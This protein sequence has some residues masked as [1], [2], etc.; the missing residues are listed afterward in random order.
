M[1]DFLDTARDQLE[2]VRGLTRHVGFKFVE[3]APFPVG[4]GIG[5]AWGKQEYVVLTVAGGGSEHQLSI[6][7][8]VLRDI[9]QDRLSALDTC[10]RLTQNNAAY[11]VYLHDAEAGW[12]ILVQQTFP[13]EVLF[14][15]PEFFASS[16]T[17]L[18]IVSAN[19][20]EEF[21]SRSSVGGVLYDWNEH[22][23]HRLFLR[24]M[25]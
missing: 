5:I 2:R 1:S 15:V 24:S 17:N 3:L 20:R 25:M 6:T 11:P 22:D 13:I 16:C 10:N 8:G 7:S 21:A 12:D 9:R 19:T 14:A 4:V 23:L 18:P